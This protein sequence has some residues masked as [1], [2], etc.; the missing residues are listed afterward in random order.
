MIGQ[1]LSVNKVRSFDLFA[2]FLMLKLWMS[3]FCGAGNGLHLLR[4]VYSNLVNQ[5][6]RISC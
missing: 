2:L 1:S 3:R 6:S 4:G 5:L